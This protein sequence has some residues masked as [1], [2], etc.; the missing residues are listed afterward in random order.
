MVRHTMALVLVAALG[1]AAA[2]QPPAVFKGHT[3][4][5]YSVAFSPKGE[6]LATGSFDNTI[7]LWDFKTGKEKA[8]LKGHTNAVY[9][10]AFSPNGEQLASASQDKTIRIWNVKDG[11]LIKELKGHTDIVQSVAYSPDGTLLASGSV[12]KSVRLWNPKDGKEVK[13]LGTHA[14]SVYA[15]AFSPDGKLLASTSNFEPGPAGKPTPPANVAVKVW[16]VKGQKELKALG[17]VTK[18]RDGVTVAAFIGN[19]KLLTGGFDKHLHLWDVAA[20]KEIKKLGPTPDDIF[21][22]AVSKDGKQVVTAGYGGSLNLWDLNTGKP[23]FTVQLKGEKKPRTVTY[24]V[25]F[26]PDGGAVVTG[27]EAGN[28]ARVTPLKKK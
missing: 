13:N 18:D 12:D 9:C 3:N 20:G 11:T 4:F 15:V 23:A 5:V 7:K 8:T 16:D 28:L 19:D 14:S 10:V 26:T 22:L 24:C 17:D 2:A 1:G 27:H 6:L 21:G 25:A